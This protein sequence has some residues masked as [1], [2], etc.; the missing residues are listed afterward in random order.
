MRDVA[1]SMMHKKEIEAYY[2]ACTVVANGDLLKPDSQSELLFP[3][4]NHY[5]SVSRDP[6]SGFKSKI[7]DQEPLEQG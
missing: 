4:L 6:E 1:E 5:Q 2:C 7:I 3:C